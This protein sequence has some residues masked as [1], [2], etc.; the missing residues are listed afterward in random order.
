MIQS[1]R[2][3]ERVEASDYLLACVAAGAATVAVARR[4]E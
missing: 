4:H 2:S 1:E 3:N